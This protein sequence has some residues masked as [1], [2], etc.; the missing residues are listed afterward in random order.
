MAKIYSPPAELERPEIDF[1]NMK[2]YDEACEK[3]KEG[4]KK[5]LLNRK[6]G[7]NIGKILRFPVADGHAEYMIASMKPLELVHIPLGDAW[8]YQ[9]DYNLT[10]KSVKEQLVKQELID[11]LFSKK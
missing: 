11:K 1:R 10:A 5:L 4:L 6:Q 9:F 8:T 7:E 2:A 3:Y